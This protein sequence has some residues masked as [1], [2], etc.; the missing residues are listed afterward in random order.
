MNLWAFLSIGTIALTAFFIFL[1]Y[2]NHQKA[3]KKM[4]LEAQQKRL[5]E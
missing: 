4:E 5:S 3:M 1:L 2:L